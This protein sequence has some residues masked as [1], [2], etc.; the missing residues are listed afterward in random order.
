MAKPYGELPLQLV[1]CHARPESFV[2]PTRNI[3]AGLG[4]ALL[5][6]EEHAVSP[7]HSSQ[8][9]VLWIVEE[10]RLA[11]LEGSPSDRPI[12]LLTGRRG[13]QTDDPR[14]IGAVHRPAGLHELYR[15]LQQQLEQHPRSSPRLATDLPATVRREGREWGASVRSLSETGCLVHSSEPLQL[16]AELELR[17][18]LPGAVRVETRAASTYELPPETG[19]V[20]EAIP[21]D[22]RA[23][24]A[25]FVEQGLAAQVA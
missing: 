5:T 6:P 19:L 3:L 22:T 21:P 8:E 12:L 11:E 14:V 24:I 18:G 23:V 15:L 16:G 10:Q 7:V 4:Y 1:V 25:A 13:V 17:F 9:P 20:F 2:G